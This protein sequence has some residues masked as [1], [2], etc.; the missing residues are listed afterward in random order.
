[1]KHLKDKHYFTTLELADL[2]EIST[3]AVHKKIKSKKIKA[4]MVGGS[5]LVTREEVQRILNVG[6]TQEDKE[7][8][9]VAVQKT[10]DEYGNVLKMLAKE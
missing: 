5:Y 1:M 7:R 9:K 8:I 10:I 4:E 3:V 2:L 6:I